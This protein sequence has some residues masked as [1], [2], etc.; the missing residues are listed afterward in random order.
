[1]GN[2]WNSES[3]IQRKIFKFDA[4]EKATELRSTLV[5]KKLIKQPDSPLCDKETIILLLC[6]IAKNRDSEMDSK[7]EFGRYLCD[8]FVDDISSGTMLKIMN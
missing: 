3:E 8:T 2:K 5:L 7:K 1:M 6:V 4:L